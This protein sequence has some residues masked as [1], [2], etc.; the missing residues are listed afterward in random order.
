[1]D[2]NTSLGHFQNP[3]SGACGRSGSEHP[4]ALCQGSKRT[5]GHFLFPGRSRLL[6]PTRKN[7]QSHLPS[8]SQ[9]DQSSHHAS[10]G[11]LPPN[12]GELERRGNFPGKAPRAGA[13]TQSSLLWT[14]VPRPCWGRAG[15]RGRERQ[16]RKVPPTAARPPL[17]PAAQS[18]RARGR[19]QA[20]AAGR[21]A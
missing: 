11:S 5:R 9:S 20:G 12:F 13:G 7:S 18:L 16:M 8:S 3:T 2:R 21:G 6:T 15:A 17:G 10:P 19:L 4:P 14:K 1:M